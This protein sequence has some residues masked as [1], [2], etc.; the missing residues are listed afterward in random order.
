[1]TE[2]F[3][4]LT[5]LFTLFSQLLSSG[6]LVQFATPTPT[7]APPSA[8]ATAV[9]PTH[10]P[11]PTSTPSPVPTHTASPV[12]TATP[13]RTATP[14]ATF[15]VA[16]VAAEED[17]TGVVFAGEPPAQK[18][19]TAVLVYPLI[20]TVPGEDT[21][22]EMMN[23]NNSAVTVKC[24]FVDSVNCRGVD[25][26]L[27][28]TALQPIAWRASTGQDG[29]GARLA[30]PV[31]SSQS[32]LKCFV[33]PTSTALASHNALQG[34]AIVSNSAGDT[35]GY[36]A[37]GFRRLMPGPFTGTVRLDGVTYEQCPD[38]LHFSALASQSGSDSELILV[39]CEDNLLLARAT[40]TVVNF[41]VINEYEQHF[42]GSYSLRCM[43]RERFSRLPAFRKSSVGT[44]T[45]HAI[46]RGTSVPVIGMVIDRFTVP[47]GGAMS[48]SSNMPFLV[49]G[50]ASTVTLPI[51]D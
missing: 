16:S 37:I 38:R 43:M 22:I 3:R 17:P 34:R 19:P 32:Q 8:T 50:R 9:P 42:S 31:F 7:V 24:H 30:P 45:M 5:A 27:T 20:S 33:Q 23:L 2:L 25:F 28:L 35:I 12:P 29:N 39:P 1:M 14:T 6:P 47:G 40:Q 15:T 41:S 4:L 51:F 49:G 44:D 10:T 46:V 13:T 26:F 18:L 21:L 36:S 11:V 48:V